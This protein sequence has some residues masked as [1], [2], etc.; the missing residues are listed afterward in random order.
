V[1][2]FPVPT[3]IDVT[4]A[5]AEGDPET[6]VVLIVSTPVG[7]SHYFL[8]A[9]GAKYIGEALTRAA[10]DAQDGGIVPIKNQLIL[11]TG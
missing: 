11:P 10:T 1:E 2:R 6:L 8:S 7:E 4:L 9:E 3:E 5:T